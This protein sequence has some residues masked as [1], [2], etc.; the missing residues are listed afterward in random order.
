MPAIAKI[1]SIFELLQKHNRIGL[2][3]KEISRTLKIPSSTCYRILAALK[4]YDYIYQRKQD[5]HYFL[6]YAHL[7]F[8][9]SVLEGM[10]E[11][12]RCLPYL[13][14]LHQQTEETTFF[15]R[16]SGRA[17][18]AMEICGFINTRVAVGRGEIMPL[19]CSASGMAVLAF[20]P[21]RERDKLIDSLELTAYTGQTIT[22]PPM[23]IER[24][25]KI[26]ETGIA[27]NMQEFH[28]GINALATPIFNRD[29]KVIGALVVVG[30]SVDLD[31]AQLMEYSEPFLKASI[32]ITQSLGGQFP[33]W[34]LESGV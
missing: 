4:K 21:K 12:T 34:V 9:E 29:S 28:N 19:H 20:L 22:D 18:V 33:S 30:T 24:L 6:G 31:E 32:D 7:R 3:N 5:L 26:R 16:Y 8:A 10:D 25:E 13:E 14:E 1:H 23:L 11:A 17:C 27:L 15:A 2:T